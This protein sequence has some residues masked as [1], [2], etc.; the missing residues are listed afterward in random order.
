MKLSRLMESAIKEIDTFGKFEQPNA[1]LVPMTIPHWRPVGKFAPSI[2]DD[3]MQALQR[4][5]LVEITGRF[6]QITEIGKEKSKELKNVNRE[7][8]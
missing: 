4:R 3:T 8:D 2:R 5:G 1:I 7:T 6:A